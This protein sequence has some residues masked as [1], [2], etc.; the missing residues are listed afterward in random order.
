MPRRKINYGNADHRTATTPIPSRGILGSCRNARFLCEPCDREHLSC[1]SG[2]FDQGR[3]VCHPA[4]E[5][6]SETSGTTR[7]RPLPRGVFANR[8]AAAPARDP[9]EKSPLSL[10]FPSGPKS[11]RPIVD[12][13]FGLLPIL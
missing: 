8:S 12:R 1:A 11:L 2:S 13:T 4:S 5:R 7:P 10:S 3:L 9:T 6:A